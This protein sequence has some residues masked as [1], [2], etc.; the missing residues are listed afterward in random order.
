MNISGPTTAFGEILTGELTPIFQYSFEYTVDNTKLTTNTVA[1]NGTVTQATGLAVLQSSTTANGTALLQSKREAKYR[2]GQ[3]ANFRFTAMYTTGIASCDQLAGLAD[4][5]GSTAAFKNGYMIGY[6][7]TTFGVHRFVNDSVVT[8]ALADCDDPLD[9]TGATGMTIDVTK[10]NVFEIRFQYLGAGKIDFLVEND[11]TGQLEVFHTIDYTN[12]NTVPSVYMP[13]FRA[14]YWVDNGGTTNNV[15]LKSASCAFFIEGKTNLLMTHQPQESS[16][17]RTI[18]ASTTENAIFT[19][20]N[21]T[22]YASK[23]NFIEIFL[24]GLSIAVNSAGANTRCTVRVVRNTTL[25][26]SP[27]YNDINTNN[28]VVEIDVAGTTLTGGTEL[29]SFYA[30]GAASIQLDFNNYNFIIEPGDTITIS[31]VVSTSTS[32]VFATLLWKELF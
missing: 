20:K 31:A 18:E 10:L 24:Q 12:A 8:V 6:I 2:A 21:K 1:N 9:G 11:S 4:E 3:G 15:T 19:I 30:V 27:D 16:G 5:T 13:N 32:D 22:S 17:T 25:G 29:A 14:T 26:G 23:T 28:S 7:G